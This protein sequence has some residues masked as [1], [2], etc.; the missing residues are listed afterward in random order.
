MS[1]SLSSTVVNVKFEV[2]LQYETLQEVAQE[3]DIGIEYFIKS[4]TNIAISE[5]A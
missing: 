2:F 1:S 5:V 4:G 3:I